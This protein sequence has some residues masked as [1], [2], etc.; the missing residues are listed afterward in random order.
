MKQ[1]NDPVSRRI[2][3]AAPHPRAETVYLTMAK[4]GCHDAHHPHARP[5][6]PEPATAAGSPGAPRDV[7]VQ[8]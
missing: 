7:Q 1:A 3:V 2:T 4:T 5:Q 8:G 6:P